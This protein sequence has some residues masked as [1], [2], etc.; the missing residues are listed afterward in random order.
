MA[1]WKKPKQRRRT[2]PA[3]GPEKSYVEVDQPPVNE[4]PAEIVQALRESCEFHAPA[5][6]ISPE[7]FATFQGR[8]Q[9]LDEERLVIEVFS[10]Q[11]YLPFKPLAFCFVSFA[12][13]TRIGVYIARVLRS[14]YKDERHLLVVEPPVEVCAVE[15]RKSFRVTVPPGSGLKIAARIN[16][17]DTVMLKGIDLSLAGA[18]VAFPRDHAEDF[19]VGAA[20]DIAMQL[21]SVRVDTFAEVKRVVGH[22]AG[23]F[24]PKFLD[25][26]GHLVPSDKMITILRNIETIWLKKKKD[27]A[28]TGG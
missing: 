8:Y 1:F 22:Q 11:D 3:P 4:T 9:S 17:T 19:H 14:D 16:P 2:R 6:V 27:E 5:V 7:Q 13:Q 28:E 18:Q 23:L 25:A 15:A 12:H 24:F 10:K 26:E 21:G 20:M